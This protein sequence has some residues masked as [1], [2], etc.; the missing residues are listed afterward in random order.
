MS[1][2]K[3]AKS[4]SEQDVPEM[5]GLECIRLTKN[6]DLPV[7]FSQ[8][9]GEITNAIV[10]IGIASR[11][12]RTRFYR[13][14]LHA[15]GHGTFFRSLGA[16]LGYIPPKGSLRDKT[17]KNNYKFSSSDQREIIK[18]IE[19]HLIINWVQCDVG[20]LKG[21]EEGLIKKYKP[22]FNI[23]HNP[24]ALALLVEM[25]NECKRVACS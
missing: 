12:L 3:E 24:S 1:S 9:I 7:A 2:F 25:R 17:N 8:H 21:I 15:L 10:Y 13:Q 11:S 6:N 4:V 19:D 5:Q 22:V 16:A 23:G 18:W 14:E 20:G